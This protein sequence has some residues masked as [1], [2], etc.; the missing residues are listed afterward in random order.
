MTR[1]LAGVVLALVTTGC[2]GAGRTPGAP[3][4][5]A[6]AGSAGASPAAPQDALVTEGYAPPDSCAACHADVAKSYASVAMARSF[7]R[8][9]AS[10]A[11][12][13]YASHNQ[14]TH[15]P[16]RFTYEMLREGDRFLQR[17]HMAG[18]AGEHGPS[19]D[20]DVTFVI[21]SGRHARTYLH[22]DPGGEL[23]ELP[24]T[25]YTQEGAWGMSPGY[26][27]A[28]QADF[29]R[30]VTY[31]CLFC[32]NAY[33]PLPRAWDSAVR[34]QLFPK[35][36]PSGIDCQRCHGPGARHV[37]LARSKSSSF[38]EV[39]GS[40]V[41]PKRLS[42]DRQMDVCMQC[43]LETTSSAAW[44]G[45]VAFGRGVF[46]FRP[47][48]DLS[49][50]RVHF[51]HPPGRG[52]DDK[53]EIAHQAYRLRQSACFRNSAMT[54]TTCHDPHR[55]PPDP[56]AHYAS[57]CLGCHALRECAPAARRSA[58]RGGAVDCIPCHMPPRRTDDVVH[59]TMTDHFIRRSQPP[60]AVRL[61]P[62]R[63]AG[64]RYAGPIVFYR[65]EEIPAGESRDLVL[66]VAS[67]LDD[68]D[69][70]SGL[71]LLRRSMA[72]RDPSE[73]EPHFQLGLTLLSMGRARDA[74][75]AL[76]RAADLAPGNLRI[77]IAL[78]GACEAA[79]QDDEALRVYDRALAL[80]PDDPEA[81]TNAGGVLARHGRL[82][83]ALAHFDSAIRA[84]DALALGNRGAVLARLGRERE[85]EADLREALRIRPG[86]AEAC[87]A[88]VTVLLARGDPAG[89]LG[90]L[91]DGALR[92]PGH[93]ALAARL[94]WIL[95]T[96]PRADVRDGRKA[97]AYAT[98]AVSLSK[99]ADARALDALAAALAEA[100]RLSEASRVAAEAGR[101][102]AAAGQKDL[103]AAIDSRRRIY[104]S[105][106]AYRD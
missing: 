83:E 53:F 47:G 11:I 13:D 95:S 89:A 38:A 70:D 104:E 20:R 42:R 57:Q 41:N 106:R 35:D 60:E 96:S 102:A 51:D 65:P 16:S 48:E 100:G 73:P 69:R 88:L 1:H 34:P 77:L 80:R 17:R 61:A 87:L 56:A 98:R 22:L 24:V 3:P 79:G 72:T 46:S 27:R 50:Y 92:N 23:T 55:R 15:A 36:L 39:R 29:F 64:D 8:P 99:R 44:S 85:A 76:R 31:I 74:V 21:G 93:A 32:H 78:G 26:D 18:P 25:W 58:E 12:E 97:L 103:A 68:V 33:P 7:A 5:P 30:P 9:D 40:I 37:L 94:A 101:V 90:V 86:L 105:G 6:G 54:C 43:H 63:E 2:G 84:G 4:P 67:L 52:H 81:H 62:R 49:K 28:D 59:V 19:F 75:T 66:G 91:G 14:L 45:L 10:P 82:Q 71:A